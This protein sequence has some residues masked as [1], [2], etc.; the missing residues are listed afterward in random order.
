MVVASKMIE[1]INDLTGKVIT[2]DALHAQ[3]RTA[4]AI[5]ERGG[6][7][8][9]QIKDNQATVRE[10]TR[11]QTEGVSPFLNVWKK[12]MDATKNAPSG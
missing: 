6:E 1:E 9:L 10:N 12:D 3:Q 5:V 7:Y 8:L 4:R 2:A 11:R